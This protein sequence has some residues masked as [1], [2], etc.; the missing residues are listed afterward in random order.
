MT[1]DVVMTA[2][3]ERKGVLEVERD[4]AAANIVRLQ[5]QI[6]AERQRYDRIVGG[7][8]EMDF[9]VQ[10]FATR[11]ESTPVEVPTGG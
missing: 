11:A 7:V 3:M 10:Q 8:L 1:T 4:R 9:M 2:L 6:D 5:E